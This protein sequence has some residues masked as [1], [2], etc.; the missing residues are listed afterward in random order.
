[1]RNDGSASELAFKKKLE[2][3]Y[4]KS[5]FVEK[6]TDTKSVKHDAVKEGFAKPAPADY[7]V[8]LKGKMFY[9]EV[10]SCSG[11]SFPFSQFT[12]AQRR[13]MVRQH[14]ADGEYWV[15]IH[16][17]KTDTWYKVYGPMLL[18]MEKDEGKKSIKWIE[19]KEFEWKV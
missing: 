17:I 15:F 14:A 10:K 4:G 12:A 16:N 11:T 13:A 19:L 3:K 9:A 5:V 6:Y 1:M 18:Q 2:D 8:T 7:V